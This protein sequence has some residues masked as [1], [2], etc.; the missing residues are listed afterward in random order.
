MNCVERKRKT[1]TKTNLAYFL[2]L[3]DKKKNES[4][5][6]IALIAN[7]LY[8]RFKAKKKKKENLYYTH[9]KLLKTI[10]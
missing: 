8:K 10:C 2:T 6:K 7:Y 1:N 5:E 9:M 3:T 4:N